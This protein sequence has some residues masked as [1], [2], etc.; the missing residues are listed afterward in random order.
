M[1]RLID[2]PTWKRKEEYLFFKTFR[3]PLVGVTV[4]VDC[5]K[6]CRKAFERQVPISLYYFHAA[7]VAV[8]RIE[9]FRYREENGQ[10]YL[11]EQVDLFTPVLTAE[12]NYRSVAIPY[13]EKLDEFVAGA[14]PVIERAKRGEGDA[15]GVEEHR[16]DL[17]LISV[18]PWFRFSGLQLSDPANPH[19]SLPIFTFGKL[20]PIEGKRVM[21]VSLR[22]NH[23]FVDGFHI[24]C[25][26]EEFQK[27]L[28]RD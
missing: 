10:V 19:E 12:N 28:D 18:N 8:N 11:Y 16:P 22:V 1:K 13:R 21:P 4:E 7:M 20:T 6:A 9:E 26:L 24:G 17:I 3:N 25:F 14:T 5:T 23:G 15:H 27:M 2:I